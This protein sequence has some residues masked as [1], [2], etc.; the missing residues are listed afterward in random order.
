MVHN[1]GSLR[2][3]SLNKLLS[4]VAQNYNWKHSRSL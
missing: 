1:Y 2:L 3:D 4:P